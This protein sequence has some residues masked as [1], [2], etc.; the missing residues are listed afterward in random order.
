MSLSSI[1]ETGIPL[2]ILGKKYLFYDGVL[3]PAIYGGIEP[4]EPPDP[5]DPPQPPPPP[6][7]NTILAAVNKEVSKT[8]RA[9]LKPIQEKLTTFDTWRQEVDT[10]FKPPEN[11]SDDPPDVDDEKKDPAKPPARVQEGALK[12]QL[13]D[14]NEQVT[15][16]RAANK[17]AESRA[18]EVT[19]KERMT[20]RDRILSDSLNQHGVVSLDGGL[21]F[22]RD[23]LTFDEE[24]EE[25]SYST[26]DGARYSIPEMVQK[27]TPDWLKK[28]AQQGGGMGGA[29]P[30][31]LAA[32]KAA[33][34]H[35]QSL[36]KKALQTSNQADSMAYWR[37][38]KEAIA[39]GIAPQ[40]LD[41][42]I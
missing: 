28:P 15:S 19:M 38:R 9:S 12:K 24:T 14:L 2:E 30:Q 35:V 29:K 7:L 31:G 26:K 21:K 27:F 40:E 18:Q 17:A 37:A 20:N 22:F 5:D 25:W 1:F 41:T 3:L 8:L 34:Q 6:D 23:D 32:Q 13:R 39:K 10:R 36:H 42:A 16:L 4:P 33:V 11:D